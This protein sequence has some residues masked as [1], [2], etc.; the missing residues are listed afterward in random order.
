MLQGIQATQEKR[1]LK[2]GRKD[3]KLC[4]A[5]DAACFKLADPWINDGSN[6]CPI[7]RVFE[8]EG[9]GGVSA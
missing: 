9:N 1:N 3:L 5:I 8:S 2:E 4:R 7:C 6:N